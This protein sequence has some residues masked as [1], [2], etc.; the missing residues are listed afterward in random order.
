M[1]PVKRKMALGSFRF[2]HAADIHLDGPTGGIAGLDDDHIVQQ[3]RRATRD[4]FEKLIDC[5]LNQKANFLVIAGDLFD[6]SDR[7]IHTGLYFCRQMGRLREA[8]VPVYVLHGNHD[9]GSGIT[10]DLPL[11]D[12]VHVFPADRVGT[13]RVETLEVVLHG[14]SYPTREVRENL[15]TSY[16]DPVPYAFNIGVLHTALDGSDGHE[17]YAPCSVADLVAK[18]YDYW[19]LGHV[20]THRV[21]HEHPHIVY[22]GKLQGRHVREP[23]PGGAV[24][25]EV[26]DGRVREL[27]FLPLD[28]VRWAVLEVDIA[29]VQTE[30]KVEKR[31]AHVLRR[32]W[33]ETDG[34]LLMCRVVLRGATPLHERLTARW[35]RLTDEVRALAAGFGPDGPQIERLDIVTEPPA[36][37]HAA[38]RDELD[39]LG[40]IL[41]ETT[42]NTKFRKRLLEELDPVLTRLPP[43]VRA[44][45]EDPVMTALLGGEPD[46]RP[47]LQAARAE[48][49]GRIDAGE[50]GEKT[51]VN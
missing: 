20:H 36:G 34:R 50:N 15:A 38:T 16:P 6:E 5:V 21:I 40:R 37:P 48:I 28:T 32:A 18:N 43:D 47:L 33:R 22:P 11:P 30:A 42:K 35:P 10:G 31:V 23:G 46:L 39:A 24:L 26:A 19:A 51:N 41:D 29:S 17:S 3:V 49:M 7:D 2:V 4:T 8:G 25:V 27:H 12:N 45:L 44:V 14:R 13:F 9:A 1:T